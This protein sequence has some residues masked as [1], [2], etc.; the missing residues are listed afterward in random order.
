MAHKGYLPGWMQTLPHRFHAFVLSIPK[1]TRTVILPV[2]RASGWAKRTVE[3]QLLQ[4]PEKQ[5][6]TDKN[7]LERPQV[8]RFE[9]RQI[10]G[11]YHQFDPT[12]WL[13]AFVIGKR[14]FISHK[15]T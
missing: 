4:I 6:F 11:F 9:R 8:T 3:N 2:G 1:I 7:P 5:N 15:T 13:T 14:T 12:N 10:T